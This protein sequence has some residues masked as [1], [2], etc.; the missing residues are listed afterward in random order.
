MN[1]R[2][3]DTRYSYIRD[4]IR[5]RQPDT[6]VPDPEDT[7]S[8]LSA[9]PQSLNRYG[10]VLNNPLRY[11]DPSG[12]APN[13]ACTGA[14]IADCGVDDWLGIEH[15]LVLKQLTDEWEE[16][17]RKVTATVKT[18]AGIAL[19]FIEPIDYA[20]TIGACL[21]GDCSLVALGLMVLPCVSGTVARQADEPVS[22]VRNLDKDLYA[23]GNKTGPRSPRVGTDVTPGIG[24]VLSPQ[25]P[26]FPNG[27]SV[28]AD[29]LNAPLT[30][31]YHRLPAGTELPTGLDVVADG[32]DVSPASPHPATHHTIFNTSEMTLERFAE[33]F[34]N[35]DWQYGGKK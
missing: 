3:T 6:I 19:G 25:T 10:Y 16:D 35:L 34:S 32:L 26:P 29:P 20:M 24:G 8:R 2:I 9:G 1:A 31:H 30:G 18:A 21:Q 27:V 22:F 33:L 7:S 4:L 14:M 11:S 5:K 17:A 28:F 12:H 23:F 13:M 15:Y